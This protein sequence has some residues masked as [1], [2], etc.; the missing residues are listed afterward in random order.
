M[1]SC[2]RDPQGPDAW[3]GPLVCFPAGCLESYFLCFFLLTIPTAFPATVLVHA[4]H[5]FHIPQALWAGWNGFGQHLTWPSSSE[6]FYHELH[7]SECWW[8]KESTLASASEE[9]LCMG[10]GF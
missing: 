8:E 5:P 6:N 3:E 7:Q 10:C 2:Q 1:A 4:L 9:T